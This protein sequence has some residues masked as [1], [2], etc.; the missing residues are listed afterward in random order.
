M[1]RGS[2]NHN[3][4][5]RLC[6]TSVL[7]KH[8]AKSSF[9]LFVFFN[10]QIRFSLGCLIHEKKHVRVSVPLWSFYVISASIV[11]RAAGRKAEQPLL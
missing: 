3:A 6:K 4:A 11:K 7:N 1:G 2:A 9:S 10:H 5:I 8:P